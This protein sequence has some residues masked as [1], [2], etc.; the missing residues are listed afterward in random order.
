MSEKNLIEKHEK[1]TENCWIIGFTVLFLF[2]DVYNHLNNR[3]D[4]KTEID[5]RDQRLTDTGAV[6]RGKIREIQ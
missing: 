6:L 3:Y 2:H 5:N 1:S 4:A